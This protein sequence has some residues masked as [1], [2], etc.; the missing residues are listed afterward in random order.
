MASLTRAC[1]CWHASALVLNEYARNCAQTKRARAH[2]QAVT[3]HLRCVTHALQA[4]APHA[5]CGSRQAAALALCDA[6]QAQAPHAR[7]GSRQAT[8]RAAVVLAVHRCTCLR[9]PDGRSLQLTTPGARIAR[10]GAA[11]PAHTNECMVS[12]IG[13]RHSGHSLDAVFAERAASDVCLAGRRAVARLRLCSLL[14]APV[15]RHLVPLMLAPPPPLPPCTP[16]CTPPCGAASLRLGAPCS[17]RRAPRVR[18]TA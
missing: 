2:A 17:S 16:P 11:S 12:A 3:M 6:L 5:R 9:A 7:C 10:A 8:F 15:T 13:S 4:Q 14:A 1:T 18:R